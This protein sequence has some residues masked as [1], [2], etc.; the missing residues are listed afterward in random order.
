MHVCHN[1]AQYLQRNKLTSF[2]LYTIIN[3]CLHQIMIYHNTISI[4]H[5]N[6]TLDNFIMDEMY[7]CKLTT[8]KISS[9]TPLVRRKYHDYNMF[10]ESC[11]ITID[12]KNKH[13]D[14]YLHL[15]E[16]QFR[17]DIYPDE[18]KPPS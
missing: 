16:K 15:Y 6:T 8:P 18:P 9:K 5:G 11:H 2:C 1:V 4:Y 17:K 14:K 10:F 13:F 12:A 7:V 3:S